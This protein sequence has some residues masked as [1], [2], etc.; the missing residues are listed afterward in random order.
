MLR[1]EAEEAVRSLQAGKFPGVDNIPFELIKNG[2]EATTTDLTARHTASKNGSLKQCQNG[3][4]I[5]LNSH[6]SK[7]IP[8]VIFNRLKAKAE[9]QASF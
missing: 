7:I 8:R 1:E 3:R 6:P 4:T 5:S 9:E 2:D